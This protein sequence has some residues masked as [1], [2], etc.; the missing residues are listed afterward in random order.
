MPKRI[1]SLFRNLFRKRAVE[2]ALDDELR[3]SVEV[4]TQEKIKQGLSP[5]VARREALIELGGIEQ[6]KEEVR[7]ARSGRILEDLARDIRLAFRSMR[8]S[9]GF[10]TVAILTLALGIGANTAMFSAVEAVLLRPLPYEHPS[11]LVTVW[12]DFSKLYGPMSL[13]N[14]EDVRKESLSLKH[15]AVWMADEVPL[16]GSGTPEEIPAARVSSNFFPLLGVVPLDGR[17]FA[18]A[19]F[20][21]GADHKAILSAGFWEKRFG[22]D[23]NAIGHGILLNRV[24][25]KIVGVMPRQFDLP[26]GADLW[27]PFVPTPAEAANRRDFQHYVV[28]RLAPGATIAQTQTELNTIAARLAREFP[29]ADL[30][31]GFK[32]MPLR[33]Y[34]AGNAG[35][36]LFVL[37]AAVGLVLLIA[38][39][40]VGGLYLAR[41]WPRMHELAI[42]AALGA[43]RRRL[44][45]QLLVEA[46]LLALAGGAAGL[47]LAEW[48]MAGL[49]SLNLLHT[50][51]LQDAKIDGH[52]LWFAFAIAVLAGIAFGLAPASAISR[53][54]L[55]AAMREAGSGREARSAGP[56]QSRLRQLLVVGE[57]ALAFVLVICAGLALRSFA[58]LSAVPLGF[59]TEHILTMQLEFPSYR[60]KTAAEYVVYSGRILQQVRVAPGVESASISDDIPMGNRRGAVS[61]RIEARPLP[62]RRQTQI[63]VYNAVTLGYFQTLGIPILAG[64]GFNENDHAGSEP[65]AIVDQA[66]ARRYFGRESPIGQ[67]ISLGDNN[68]GHPIWDEIV[69]E[70]GN[71][72]DVSPSQKH[73]PF[74]YRP[75]A[76]QGTPAV[77]DLEVRTG[78][79]PMAL[80]RTIKDRIWSVDKNQPITQMATMSQAVATAY[81]EPRSRSLLLS[82]FGGLGLTLALVGVYGV[83]SY[84]IARRTWEIGIRVALGAQSGD[85]LRLVVGQGAKLVLAGVAIGLGASFVAARLMRGL[86]YGISATDPLTFA[87]VSVLVALAGLAASY[88]PARH[89]MR[90]DPNVALRHE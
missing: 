14:L 57:V 25:Y 79:E 3:S 17:T 58:R 24:T 50:S 43:S 31:V 84:S 28:G 47:L 42:R 85:V 49:R 65:V 16:T 66:F 18:P 62:T 54:R 19:D 44:I 7:A 60:L 22:G 71:V 73:T 38:C 20:Q 41:G 1:L 39:A 55:M 75:L 30:H 15:L 29:G 61:F 37:F 34:F 21:P 46:S 32:A 59:R 83:V 52:V 87:S 4:L 74:I 70:V 80:A 23:P 35:T 77:V 63:A 76:Q 68:Q 67:H 26:R 86:L 90:V 33:T 88:I 51:L 81:S 64:R 69:G 2:Q 78:T 56:Q 9:P 11:Q 36:P 72:R 5:S 6:V 89:A 45:R 8:K 40:N 27:I 82:L 48:A 12:T 13:P 53:D 10:T